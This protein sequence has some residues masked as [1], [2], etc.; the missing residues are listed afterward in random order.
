MHPTWGAEDD[1]DNEDDGVDDKT[2]MVA[3]IFSEKKA[4]VI[5]LGSFQWF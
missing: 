2:K 3:N 4:Y 1:G 5:F